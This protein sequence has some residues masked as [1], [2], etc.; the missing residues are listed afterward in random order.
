MARPAIMPTELRTAAKAILA[1]YNIEYTGT[2]FRI[3]KPNFNPAYGLWARYDAHQFFT[4]S[5]RRIGGCCGVIEMYQCE[6]P[7]DHRLPV[8]IT[9]DEW[10]TLFKYH[11]RHILQIHHRRIGLVTLINSQTAFVPY[12][13]AAGFKLVATGFNPSTRRNNNIWVLSI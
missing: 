7:T 2:A 9:T 6:A 12:L 13:E 3:E 1:K 11:V 10:I 4:M 5:S 8:A